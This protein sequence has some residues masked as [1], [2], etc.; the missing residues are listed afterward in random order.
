MT[1]LC[2]VEAAALPSQ[3]TQVE[4][5]RR[6]RTNLPHADVARIFAASFPSLPVAINFARR[7]QA[8]VLCCRGSQRTLDKEQWTMSCRCR[9]AGCLPGI[10]TALRG[11]LI[12]IAKRQLRGR[13]GLTRYVAA[14][15]APQTVLQIQFLK[16]CGERILM[17]ASLYVGSAW[18][19]RH[20][21]SVRTQISSIFRS[22]SF[23][24]AKHLAQSP[25][26]TYKRRSWA[27][28]KSQR[29]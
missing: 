8:F 29:E 26:T 11:Q 3:W 13:T 25:M 16:G 6:H 17:G 7:W 24:L 9:R 18:H 23:H 22:D 27:K 1:Q 28:R 12:K 4:T 5:A 15:I 14:L 19:L 20:F 21:Q 10:F 2:L